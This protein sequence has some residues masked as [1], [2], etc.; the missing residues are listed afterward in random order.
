MPR[1]KD[2]LTQVALGRG[3][4]A[5][6]SPVDGRAGVKGPAK[7]LENGFCYMVGFITIEQFHMN[8]CAGAVGEGL[9]KLP[10]KDNVEITFSTNEDFPHLLGEMMVV[11]MPLS[12]LLLSL[13]ASGS[14]F[15]NEW[16]LTVVP[17]MK[18]ESFMFSFLNYTF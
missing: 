9:E 4:L 13:A 18:G 10:D 5:L 7:R 3:D 11:L 14:R 1:R 17:Y 16:L 15:V 8:I 6:S 2:G 12:R